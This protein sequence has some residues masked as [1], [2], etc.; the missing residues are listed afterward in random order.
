MSFDFMEDDRRRL[1][2]GCNAI[3][4]IL[5][6]SKGS[7]FVERKG[8]AQLLKNPMVLQF[9]WFFLCSIEVNT[10]LQP[11]I[12]FGFFK[13]NERKICLISAKLQT[14]KSSKFSEDVASQ[15]PVSTKILL[16]G[17]GQQQQLLHCQCHHEELAELLARH[18]D[19]VKVPSRESAKNWVSQSL[20]PYLHLRKEHMVVSFAPITPFLQLRS[21]FSHIFDDDRCASSSLSSSLTSEDLHWGSRSTYFFPH[22]AVDSF[23]SVCSLDP[24]NCKLSEASKTTT[25]EDET[26]LNQMLIYPGEGVGVGG[27]HTRSLLPLSG[28]VAVVGTVITGGKQTPKVF[29]FTFSSSRCCCCCFILGITR[30]RRPPL[31][32]QVHPRQTKR[33]PSLNFGS[34]SFNGSVFRYLLLLGESRTVLDAARGPFVAAAACG[35]VCTSAMAEKKRGWRGF[36]LLRIFC[37]LFKIPC[38]FRWSV[39]YLSILLFFLFPPRTRARHVGRPRNP[40]PESRALNNR[41]PWSRGRDESRALKNKSRSR[42]P[43]SG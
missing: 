8:H 27:E 18:G 30:S 25:D 5:R 24:P 13:K 22:I 3:I 29:S 7:G 10:V 41:G 23:L 20:H 9:V 26:K 2:L 12:S 39:G 43:R 1:L 35:S 28:T 32:S 21:S 15:K 40:G 37:L 17:G 6:V 19:G 16:L 33:N 36:R 14:T 11:Q 34:G 38:R 4:S 42:I 31:Q